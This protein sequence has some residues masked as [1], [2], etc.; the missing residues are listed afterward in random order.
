MA[1]VHA[2]LLLTMLPYL[3]CRIN[4][5]PYGLSTESASLN[6][7]EGGGARGGSR[8]EEVDWLSLDWYTT[9]LKLSR[10]FLNS[11]CLKRTS[12][13]ALNISKLP[14]GAP[15][16]LPSPPYIVCSRVILPNQLYK[17]NYYLKY[18]I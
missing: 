7:Y 2:L 14:L 6:H 10:A 3:H 9:V 5:N 1:E 11:P 16:L 8:C 18:S 15:S 4:G 17:Y 13:S 12:P